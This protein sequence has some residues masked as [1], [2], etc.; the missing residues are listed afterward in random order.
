MPL[1]NNFLGCFVPTSIIEFKYHFVFSGR[2]L[3]IYAEVGYIGHIDIFTVQ[4]DF[5]RVL[6]AYSMQKDAFFVSF[7]FVLK[8]DLRSNGIHCNI[9]I[10]T[11]GAKTIHLP[12]N[13]QF[14]VAVRQLL[15]VIQLIA[16]T[17][18][19][20]SEESSSKRIDGLF[21]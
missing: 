8:A 4:P 20:F 5:H 14:V 10:C 9:H 11:V 16:V 12:D 17:K 18:T 19:Y 7:K 21:V 1:K 15:G 13:L 2:K 3:Q 6:R